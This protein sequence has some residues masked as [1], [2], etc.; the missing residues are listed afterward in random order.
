MSSVIDVLNSKGNNVVCVAPDS[1]VQDAAHR[2]AQYKIGAVLVTRGSDIL[3]IFTER[4]LLNRVVAADKDPRATP[5]S[6]VMTAPVACGTPQTKLA[7]CRAVM[8]RGR[9]R[10]LPI[11]DNGRLV[12]M[13]SSGD[14]LAR[15]NHEAQ[16]TIHYLHEYMYGRA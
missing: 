15:E 2:M 9:L 3:G 11:V 14:I 16:E 7:E 1:T 4:D 5:V 13:I 6:E 12:G 8:T 10:H